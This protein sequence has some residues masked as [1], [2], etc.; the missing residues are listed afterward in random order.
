VSELT[1]DSLQQLLNNMAIAGYS[2]SSVKKARTYIAAA[3]DYA[4]DERLIPRNPAAK[5]EL[6]GAKLRRPP[7]R[8]YSLEEVRR[9]FSAAAAVSVREHLIVRVFYLCGLRS[10]E[11]FALRIDDIEPG[12]LRIDEALKETE[13]GVER[14]GRD[15]D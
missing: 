12:L 5:V 3:L 14:I 13:R 10:G 9:L 7:K 11:L 1:R 2:Y 6:P 15:E 4:V 8:E